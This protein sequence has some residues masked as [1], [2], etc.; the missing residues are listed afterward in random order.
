MDRRETPTST[1][2]ATIHPGK[3]SSNPNRSDFTALLV[4]LIRL[5][6]QKTDLL[7]TINIPHI[8]GHYDPSEIDLEGGDAGKLIRDG[9]AMRDEILRSLEI[10]RW[11]LFSP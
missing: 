3:G 2:L 5:E 11:E 7:V 6:R 9:F 1:L 10:L 4:I 8:P